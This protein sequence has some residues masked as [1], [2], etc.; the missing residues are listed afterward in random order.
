MENTN[1]NNQPFTWKGGQS[2]LRSRNLPKPFRSQST[3]AFTLIELLVV[4][5]IIAIL[6][7]MLLPALSKAKA[8]GQQISCLNNEKQLTLAW[9]LYIDDYNNF[10]PPNTV[11]GAMG[12]QSSDESWIRGNARTDRDPKN[13]QNGVLFKYNDSV[14]IYHCPSDKSKVTRF[15][16]LLRTRSY[17]MSTGLAHSNPNFFKVIKKFSEII[18]PAPSQASVFLDEDE[19]AIQNGAIGIEPIHTGNY[20]HWNLPGS[21]HSY[22]ASI[23]FADGHAEYWR[24]KDQWIAAGAKLLK[25]RYDADM[26]NP[27]GSAP[28]SKTDRDL[29]RLQ[30]TVPF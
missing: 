27:D 6:A 26:F 28:S 12:D 22:G 14:A 23:S 21:R 24:W 5:A 1:G 8:K 10:L 4:I 11:A 13:I 29:Q 20:Q 18:D 25:Q 2:M 3:S 7:S 16:N 15:P 17:S 19:W 30:K 9:L